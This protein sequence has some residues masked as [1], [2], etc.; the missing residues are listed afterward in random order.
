M[1][2]IVTSDARAQLQTGYQILVASSADALKADQGDLWDSGKVA[3]DDTIAIVYAGKPLASHQKCFWKVRVWDS[4]DAASDWGEPASWVVGLLEPG[5]WKADWIGSDKLRESAADQSLT[6][7]G[8]KW[9]S[10]P[11][12]GNPPAGPQLF[13]TTWT[14]PADVTVKQA[15]LVV[16]AD[17]S[18]KFVINGEL[19][20]EHQTWRTAKVVDIAKYLKPGVNS[21]RCELTNGEA[22]PT[23]LI[24]KPGLLS[25]QTAKL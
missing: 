22:G 23:G 4:Q 25:P 16:A 21:L 9:I 3:S 1:S 10:Y 15:Q 24:A 13:V 5:D 11:F 19:V 7:A 20:A 12:D 17:D 2:W 18:C 8:A 6:L 14:L